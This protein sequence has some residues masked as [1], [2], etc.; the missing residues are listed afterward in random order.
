[1]RA[2]APVLLAAVI[3][4]G[5]AELGYRNRVV[6]RV[7]SPADPTLVAVCQE[8]PEFDGPGY[9]V[10]LERPDA[11]VVRRL[12]TSGDGDP[13]HELAWS[14]DGRTLAVVS[15]HVA[16][17]AVIDVERALAHPTERPSRSLWRSVSLGDGNRPQLARHVRFVAPGELEYEVCPNRFGKGIDWRICTAPVEVRRLRLPG[18]ASTIGL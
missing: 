14:I 6:H 17:L 3:G 7:P 8:V 16:R 1:M 13:C 2:T 11:T 9:E 5:C 4:S 15:S 12:Y 10:R 18:P